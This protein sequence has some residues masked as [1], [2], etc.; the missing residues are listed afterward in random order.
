M[1]R[2]WWKA[3]LIG[4]LIWFL[5]VVGILAFNA[6]WITSHSEGEAIDAVR[7]QEMSAKVGQLSGYCLMGIWFYVGII[8]SR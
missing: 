4:T 2:K 8:R 6:W 7:M 1:R 5:A 3:G